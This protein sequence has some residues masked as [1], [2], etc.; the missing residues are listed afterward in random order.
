[1]KIDALTEAE[2]KFAELLWANVPINSTLLV[3]LCEKELG[4][5]KSTTYTMLKK[6]CSK[7]LFQ[8]QD[9]LVQTLQTKEEYRRQQGVRLVEERFGGS[10][11][12]FLTAFFGDRP[13]T[14]GQAQEIRELIDA[15]TEP[16]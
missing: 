7:G 11:P 8:N 4:W 16:D 14:P 2:E 1:M 13:L 3:G 12:R 6:L 10:L 5:K 15:Y 9:A